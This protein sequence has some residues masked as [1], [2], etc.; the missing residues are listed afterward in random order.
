MKTLRL[1]LLTLFIFIS[2][3][4]A[5]KM[6]PEPF[7]SISSSNSSDLAANSFGNAI[8]IWDSLL[9]EVKASYFSNGAWG[10][11]QTLDSGFIVDPVRVAFDDSGTG[12]AL[13]Y[14]MATG[15]IK[16]SFFNGST[17]A[18][19]PPDPL[20]VISAFITLSADIAM[21]GTGNGIALWI[22]PNTTNVRSSNFFGGSWTA[23][24]TIGV[25][26]ESASIAY[27]S[28]GTAVAGWINAGSVIVDNYSGGVWQGP[29]TLD[30]GTKVIVGIDANGN[31][32]ASWLNAVGDVVVSFFDGATWSSPQTISTT[33]GNLEISFAMSPNGTAVL[34]WVNSGFNGE[35]S[36]FNG[37]TWTSPILF[38]FG[39]QECFGDLQ[40]SVSVDV[41]GNALVLFA[42]PNAIYSARLLIGTNTWIDLSIVYAAPYDCILSLDAALSLTGRGF[43]V[44]RP[45]VIENVNV[46]G[47]FTLDPL[48]PSSFDGNTCTN[49]FATQSDRVNILTFNPSLDPLIAAYYLRDNGQLIAIIPARGPY[50]YYDHNRCKNAKNVYTLTAV[51]IFGQESSSLTITLR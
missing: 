27:S 22:D 46:F 1:I 16:T 39:I 37:V 50:I 30:A 2:A 49:R 9:P 26:T 28:N 4:A 36:S 51:N 14:R 35:S 31:A 17:W 6:P 23:P 43:A 45:L 47:S 24:L 8:A 38:G 15:E 21:N 7:L 25:G 13:W 34:T 3:H 32:I 12:I 44:W 19:P 20:D 18:I 33:S 10:P 41:N 48:P 42:T 40:I 29:I 5:W 11:Y